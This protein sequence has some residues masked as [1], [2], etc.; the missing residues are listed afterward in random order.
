MAI[1]QLSR[2]QHRRGRKLTGTGMPQLASGELGWAIDTQEL[3]IGNGAVSEGSPAVGNT[4]VLTE[5]DN[6]FELTEQYSY[7]NGVIADTFAR[8]LQR[9]LDD[10][11]SVRAFGAFGDN[12]DQTIQIQKAINSLYKPS[13][14]NL[15]NNERVVLYVPEGTY[16]VSSPILV[17]SYVTLIGAGKEKTFIKSSNSSVFETISRG[18]LPPTTQTQ[19]KYISIEG[20]TIEVSNAQHPGIRLNG[21]EHSVF[22]D[23]K[24][25]GIGS[26]AANFPSLFTHNAFRFDAL[27]GSLALISKHNVFENIEFE[28]FHTGFFSEQR[29]EHNTIKNSTFDDMSNGIWFGTPGSPTGPSFNVIENST[30]DNIVNEAI[31]VES[32]NY[33]TSKNNKFLNVGNN[34]GSQDFGISSV[35]RFMTNTNISDLD[36]FQRTELSLNKTTDPSQNKFYHPEILGSTNYRNLYAN[37]TSINFRTISS[38]DLDLLKLPFLERG[39]IIIDYVYEYVPPSDQLFNYILREGTL[40]IICNSI[41]NTVTLNEEYNFTG[42]FSLE[43]FLQFSVS[44]VDTGIDENIVSLKAVNPNFSIVGTDKFYYTIRTKS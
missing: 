12:T 34:L 19:P 37:E 4:K 35:I 10:F 6:L 25:R 7:R 20:M 32:G 1:V 23:L 43:E 11:V 2:I 21:C 9:R 24:F 29:I 27:G 28:G 17:P 5:H 18:L 33:N 3:Y 39:S 15:N 13:L 30:F 40:E 44:I 16:I 38:S 14:D 42:D 8:S 36:Y 26:A 22:R 41:Q 31:V